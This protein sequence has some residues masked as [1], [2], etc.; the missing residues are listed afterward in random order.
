LA[1]S[2]NRIQSRLQ[3]FLLANLKPEV[4]DVLMPEDFVEIYNEVANDLNET[5]Q[6]R[7]EHYYKLTST[8]SAEDTS[9]TN[10]LLQG[11]IKKVLS[12][13]FET[14]GWKDIRYTYINDRIVFKAANAAGIQMD[15]WY[16][17]QCEEVSGNSDEIDLDNSVLPEYLELLKVKIM[18]DYGGMTD[19][20]YENKLQHYS[21]KARQKVKIHSLSD[22]GI[23]RSWLEQS[24]DDTVYEIVNQWISQD[25]FATNLDG[26]LVYVGD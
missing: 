23:R 25:N 4:I 11:I 10:F 5:A 6:L 7:I 15:I 9:M 17:R 3:P 19:I 1:I 26:D 13:K 22:Q 20:D 8:T 16:L 21:L 12:F 24:G 14:S 18:Q 2:I